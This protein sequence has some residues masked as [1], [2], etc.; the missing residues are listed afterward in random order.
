[1]HYGK[2][3]SGKFL[4]RP[5]RFIA[6]VEV[7]GKQETVHVK[8]TGRCR[9]LLQPGCIGYLEE[10]N[11]PAR[12]TKYDLI[13]AEKQ[14]P[15]QAP[16]LVNMDSQVPNAV[17]AEWLPKSGLFSENA[18]IRREVVFGSSRFDLYIED[19]ER[20]CFMEVK[21]VT[22]EKDGIVSFPDA[23]TERGVKHL[24]E[25][26]K[27][28]AAGYEAAILFVVQMKE[29]R[30]FHPA[31]AIHPEFG[32]ALRDAVANGVQIYVCDC[33]VTPD[34]IQI[35]AQLPIE[36]NYHETT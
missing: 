13:V 17:A 32:T 5:N 35:D 30:L 22:L 9:E 10:G 7:A 14:R 11:N 25:L 16:L 21:G 20:R 6:Y 31:D 4:V 12:K 34:T 29:M 33:L 28:V 8:N 19:G 24:Q 27:C 36:L 18:Q 23:P 26:T 2:V 15:G 3:I 1:M